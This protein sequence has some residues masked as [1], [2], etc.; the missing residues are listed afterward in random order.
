MRSGYSGLQRNSLA[1]VKS[2]V[3]LV[4]VTDDRDLV[5]VSSLPEMSRTAISERYEMS[6]SVRSM[7]RVC[8]F[9]H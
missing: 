2:I 4:F 9:L 7:N 1:L 8:V 5:Q 6:S 3:V